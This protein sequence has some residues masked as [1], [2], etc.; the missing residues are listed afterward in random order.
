MVVI[1]ISA[2]RPVVQTQLILTLAGG[3]L[4]VAIAPPYNRFA[5]KKHNVFPLCS[6]TS[7]DMAFFRNPRPPP[8]PQKIA[9]RS[10]KLRFSSFWAQKCDTAGFGDVEGRVSD[11]FATGLLVSTSRAQSLLQRARA[12]CYLLHI[13]ETYSGSGSAPM[14]GMLD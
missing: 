2:Q 11:G 1:L 5:L 3:S 9:A 12:N 14:Y 13:A 4:S 10:S 8:P 7:N 6:N